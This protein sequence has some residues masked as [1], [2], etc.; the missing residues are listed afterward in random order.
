MRNSVTPDNPEII[1]GALGMIESRGWIQCLRYTECP[2]LTNYSST[3]DP[4]DNTTWPVSIR[5]AVNLAAGYAV[6]TPYAC[7][8]DDADTDPRVPAIMAIV[9]RLG[10]DEPADEFVRECPDEVLAEWERA[11]G[12]TRQQV[13]DVLRETAE[14]AGVTL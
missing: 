8:V 7:G 4:D 9:R 14:T 11:S 6:D 3:Y 1:R 12:R 10:L 2:D 5:G 13:L